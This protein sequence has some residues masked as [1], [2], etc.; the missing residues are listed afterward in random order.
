MNGPEQPSWRKNMVSWFDT[1]HGDFGLAYDHGQLVRF[2]NDKTQPIGL[3]D[4]LLFVC[5]QIAA[6]RDES[7]HKTARVA[8]LQAIAAA[9]KEGA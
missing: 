7:W 6:G 3:R 2:H 5:V 8:W 4:S 1:N 9:L